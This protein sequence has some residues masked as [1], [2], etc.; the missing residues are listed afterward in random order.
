MAGKHVAAFGIELPRPETV[1]PVPNEGEA[2]SPPASSPAH[3]NLLSHLSLAFK[4]DFP[5]TC[6]KQW[7]WTEVSLDGFDLP[8]LLCRCLL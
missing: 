3:Q 8:W 5:N 2:G 4:L 6:T 7:V 1:G